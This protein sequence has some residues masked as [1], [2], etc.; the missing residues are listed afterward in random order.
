MKSEECTFIEE[1]NDLFFIHV[2]IFRAQSKRLQMHTH[3]IGPERLSHLH[4]QKSEHAI[5]VLMEKLRYF[6]CQD[7]TIAKYEG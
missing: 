2:L 3:F 5:V 1:C 4:N 6:H 7:Q